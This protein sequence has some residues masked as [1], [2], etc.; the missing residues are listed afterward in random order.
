MGLNTFVYMLS[1]YLICTLIQSLG[2]GFVAAWAWLALSNEVINLYDPTRLR[3]WK[4]AGFLLLYFGLGILLVPL[5]LILMSVEQHLIP[6]KNMQEKIMEFE[7][8]FDRHLS[9]D[10]WE[11]RVGTNSD[12]VMDTINNEIKLVVRAITDILENGKISWQVVT[13]AR[14]VRPNGINPDLEYYES[15]PALTPQGVIEMEY[16]IVGQNKITLVILISLVALFLRATPMG[17]TMLLSAV[18]VYTWQDMVEKYQIMGVETSPIEEG[19]YVITREFMGWTFSKC[20]G[21]SYQGVLHAPYHGAHRSDIRIGGRILRP[22]FVSIDCDLITWGGMPSFGSLEPDSMIVVNHE[23]EIERRSMKVEHLYDDEID[24]F[25]WAGKSKPGESGSGVWKVTPGESGNVLTL[26]GLVGRW[27]RSEGTITEVAVRPA[28]DSSK[29][30]LNKPLQRI[31]LH[32]GAGK[33]FRVIPSLVHKY[34]AEGNK[35]KILIL[36]P[37]RIVCKELYHS[38]IRRFPCVG[39]SMK[40]HNRHRKPMARIQITTHHTFL[41]MVTKGSV[42]TTNIGMVMVDEAHVDNAATLL[43]VKFAEN[44]AIEG[45]KAVLL[46]ATFQDEMDSGSN[47]P[48]ADIN[49]DADKDYETVVRCA[50]AGKR[51]L[52]FV[53]G[54]A[55]RY[56][57]KERAYELQKH[58]ITAM[59][60]GRQNYSDVHEKVNNKEISVIVSTNIAE[61][62]MNIDCDVV[63]NTAQEFDYYVSD[64]IVT[65]STRTIGQSSWIQRRGRCGRTK[66]GEHYYTAKAVENHRDKANIRDAEILAAGRS[67]TGNLYIDSEIQLSDEQ[68]QIWLEQDIPPQVVHLLYDSRGVKLTGRGLQMS[69][70]DWTRNAPAQLVCGCG[71]CPERCKWFDM[72]VHDMLCSARSGLTIPANGAML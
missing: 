21:V 38:L 45:K 28:I 56:G 1:S 41:N 59:P 31:I 5:A 27:A 63:V 62:G 71:K 39:L 18:F 72:R 57:A 34:L 26:V 46:S 60:L 35:G 24:S 55:G 30:T 14:R 32:P 3:M 61:C 6:W 23:N 42:E 12:N 64:G 49:I 36:G 52:W 51:V 58:G 44:I 66:A 8:W 69:M 29:I 17:L 70:E 47:Y 16:K 65:G 53:P 13:R 37:T 48:I 9:M 25:S 33:T 50:E 2:L 10:N 4:V 67:W 54:F 20:M 7:M 22:Y 43:C 40:G 19:S 11:I 15:G 68:F